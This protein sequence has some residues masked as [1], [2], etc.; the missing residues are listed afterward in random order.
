MSKILLFKFDEGLLNAKIIKRPS[1]QCKTP[2][3]AD[4]IYKNNDE[5]INTLAHT[6]ALGCCG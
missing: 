4:I 1:A 5:T 2:Y 3:V 6:P